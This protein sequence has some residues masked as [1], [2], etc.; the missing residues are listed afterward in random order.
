MQQPKA[1]GSGLIMDNGTR[2]AVH[3]VRYYPYQFCNCKFRIEIAS[4]SRLS[5]SGNSASQ[6]V[7]VIESESV[8]S[9]D[10]IFVRAAKTDLSIC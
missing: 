6:Q 10:S 7:F 9:V 1:I 8:L 3:T 5:A 2:L 4:S